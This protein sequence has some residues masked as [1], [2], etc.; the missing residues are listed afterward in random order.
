MFEYATSGTCSRRIRFNIK[1]NKVY[2]VVF[3][4]GCNGNLNGISRL[5]EGMDAETLIKQ[6][7]DVDCGGRGTSCPDQLAKAISQALVQSR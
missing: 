5:V 2:D 6:L 1:D 7:K 3:E 4:G